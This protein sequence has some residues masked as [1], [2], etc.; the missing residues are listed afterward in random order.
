[1]LVFNEIPKINGAAA[2]AVI[3]ATN[4]IE[5]EYD[6]QSAIWPYSI[7]ISKRGGVAITDTQYFRVLY[8]N[9]VEDALTQKPAAILGQPDLQS[10]G[11]NQYKLK[12]SANTLNWCYDT[13]F[14]SNKSYMDFEHKDYNYIDPKKH[15]K[16]KLY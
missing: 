13:H 10:N 8:W 16:N 12:P 14:Y 1:V 3:G 6:P 11:Q 4:F 9:S 15:P 5:K 7:K 2:D